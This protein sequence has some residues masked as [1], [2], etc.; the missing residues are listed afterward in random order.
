MKF[1]EDFVDKGKKE[2]FKIEKI[3]D[4]YL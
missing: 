1:K 2:Q 4:F 3:F